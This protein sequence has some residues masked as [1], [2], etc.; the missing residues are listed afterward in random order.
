MNHPWPGNIR[1]LTHVLRRAVSIAMDQLITVE[2]LM[3]RPGPPSRQL[4][5]SP[6]KALSGHQAVFEAE[7]GAVRSAL[8]NAEWDVSAAAVLFGVSRATFYRKMQQHQIRRSPP[9]RRH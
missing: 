7:A 2:D 1:E 4:L 3:L 6:P 5:V 8:D 9:E